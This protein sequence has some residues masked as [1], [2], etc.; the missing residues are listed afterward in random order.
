MEAEGIGMLHA[1]NHIGELHIGPYPV[2]GYNPNSKTGYEI[3]G[4]Y[5]HGCFTC[6][7]DQDETG[8]QR[9]KNTETKENY[10]RHKGYNMKIMWEHTF[11]PL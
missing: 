2:D 11:K 10:L 5:F 7:M 4:C 8:Q 6:K 9:K 1:C 3:H